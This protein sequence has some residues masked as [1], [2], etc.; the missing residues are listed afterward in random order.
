MGYPQLP[1]PT[2][3]TAGE[4]IKPM[5]KHGGQLAMLIARRKAR[6]TAERVRAPREDAAG[7]GIE[8]GRT[9]GG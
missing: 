2:V 4:P 6:D 8:A 9:G 7:Q 3:N 1:G 5:R